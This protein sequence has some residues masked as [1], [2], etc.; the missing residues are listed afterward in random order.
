M[1]REPVNT[2]GHYSTWIWHWVC[3]RIDCKGADPVRVP[4]YQLPE[5]E[6]M[7]RRGWFVAKHWGDRCPD[8]VKAGLVDDVE[9]YGAQAATTSA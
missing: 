9:P 7:C 6:E 2:K 5:P 4:K 3:D 1:T 8:C